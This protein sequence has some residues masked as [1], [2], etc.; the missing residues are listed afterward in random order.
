MD[1]LAIDEDKEAEEEIKAYEVTCRVDL[2]AGSRLLV[3]SW[4]KKIDLVGSGGE[5][6][7]SSI[8]SPL[9][10]VNS[11]AVVEGRS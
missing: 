8:S 10:R 1:S 2:L 4:K 11:G 7:V 9:V 6:K 5:L 3:G